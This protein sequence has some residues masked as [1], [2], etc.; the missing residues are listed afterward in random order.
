[1]PHW[2]VAHRQARGGEAGGGDAG[3]AV[4]DVALREPDL[5]HHL[6]DLLHLGVVEGDLVG[7]PL[8][9]DVGAVEA[10][11]DVLH[12]VGE[13]PAGGVTGLDADAPRRDAVL[14]HGVG[15]RHEVVPGLGDLVAVLLEHRRRVPDQAL[16]VALVG[17]AEDLAVD[18]H[19]LPQG[20]GVVLAVG[21]EHLLGHRDDVVRQVGGQAGLRDD[22]DVG[23]LPAL[24]GDADLG[25]E[26]AGAAVG[27]GGAGLLGEGLEGLLEAV[28]LGAGLGTG[29]GHL[30]VALGRR[31]VALPARVA[32]DVLV[33][34]A[35][36]ARRRQQRQREQ[37][38]RADGGRASARWCGF[39]SAFPLW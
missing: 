2:P 11:H 1:M 19:E 4:E 5:L 16:D 10:Q 14:L 31:T 23:Q 9:E 34:V 7:D 38:R 32:G 37:R 28:R 3:P 24:G 27:D 36:R 21:V 29:D 35:L 25:L 15:Q 17:H 20:L 30:A 39:S 18:G 22:A 26:V 33:V 6:G 12:P 13:R 8:V